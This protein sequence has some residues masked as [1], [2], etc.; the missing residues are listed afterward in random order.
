MLKNDA[1][2]VF[3]ISG[4][5]MLLAFDTTKVMLITTVGGGE[6]WRRGEGQSEEEGRAEGEEGRRKWG[7]GKKGGEEE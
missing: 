5:T 4:K 6:G 2:E 1:L 7:Q 3:L